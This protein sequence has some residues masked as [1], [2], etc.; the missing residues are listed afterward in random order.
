LPEIPILFPFSSYDLP[1]GGEILLYKNMKIKVESAE[2]LLG[3]PIKLPAVF[4]PPLFSLSL[5]LLC[6]VLTFLTP[7][8]LSPF[9]TGLFKTCNP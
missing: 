4:F 3:L 5:I 1:L 9:A 7:Y 6:S 2:K 8:A